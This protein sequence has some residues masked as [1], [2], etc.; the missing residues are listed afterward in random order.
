[1]HSCAERSLAYSPCLLSRSLR[2]APGAAAAPPTAAPI[3]TDAILK[4]IND[5]RHRPDPDRLPPVVRALS[6]M[7]AFKDSE[8]SGAYIGFIAGVLG[9]NPARA[10]ALVDRDVA[11]CAGRSLGA[12]ARHRLFG[13]AELER[14][15]HRFRRPDAGAPSHD[16]P[17]SGRQAADARSDRVSRR[18]SPACS[19]RSRS[20]S[21]SATATRKRWRSSRARN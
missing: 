17:L 18:R 3:S 16:R 21:N 8:T 1:M 20:R 7:Q 12:G 9:A 15:A 19:T 14:P 13:S 11:D 5:Y 10:I 2:R 4:W 6:E